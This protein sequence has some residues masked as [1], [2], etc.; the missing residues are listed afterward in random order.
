MSASLHARLFVATYHQRGPEQS[1]LGHLYHE[2]SF[3]EPIGAFGQRKDFADFAN[4]SIH[5]T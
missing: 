4:E 2:K 1:K 3:T 5:A